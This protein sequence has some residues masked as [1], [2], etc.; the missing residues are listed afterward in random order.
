MA[1]MLQTPAMKTTLISQWDTKPHCGDLF[2]MSS[3]FPSLE[4]VLLFS[5]SLDHGRMFAWPMPCL[6][7]RAIAKISDNT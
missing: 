3:S 1:S 6:I 2:N 7:R 5:H 4:S